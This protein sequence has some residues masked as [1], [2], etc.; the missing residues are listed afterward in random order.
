M[1]SHSGQTMG[2]EAWTA[3]CTFCD[4]PLSEQL[5]ALQHYPSNATTLPTGIPDHGGLTLCPD[6]AIHV[7]ELLF[8]WDPHGQ[9][10]VSTDHP[11]GDGYQ[12]LTPNCSFCGETCEHEV[13]GVE[14]YRRVDDELPAYA[15]YTL[16]KSCQSVF[17]EF[18]Q[19]V[20]RTAEK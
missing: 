20:R 3:S 19:N 15:N 2:V 5:L 10:P 7:S 6:C 9:P 17:G 18:L 12:K 4:C 13:L 8:S 1:S 11:I 16:C 14:L